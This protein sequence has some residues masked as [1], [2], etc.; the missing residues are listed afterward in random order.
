MVIMQQ[1][2][3]A[4]PRNVARKANR[5]PARRPGRPS[6]MGMGS[7]TQSDEMWRALCQLH[8]R[9][10]LTFAVRLTGGDEARAD[11]IVQRTLVLAWRNADRLGSV[12]GLRP[13]LMTTARR[14]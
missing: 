12:A 1:V 5:T 8:A 4:S 10:L 3:N 11:D 13:W 2:L 9:P 14:V 7:I 6:A